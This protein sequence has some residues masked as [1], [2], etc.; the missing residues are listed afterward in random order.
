[1]GGVLTIGELSSATSL[2]MGFADLYS[3]T[4]HPE[5]A[6]VLHITIDAR[7]Q[8]TDGT[9]FQFQA[10]SSGDPLQH[11]LIRSC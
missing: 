11:L 9:R 8:L 7:G 3:Q 4:L 5:G 2:R 10:V 1:V 6:Q